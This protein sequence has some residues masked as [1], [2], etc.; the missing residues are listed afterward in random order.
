LAGGS[1]LAALML[2]G[3]IVAAFVGSMFA[4]AVHLRRRYARGTVLAVLLPIIGLA[5]L[6]VVLSLDLALSAIY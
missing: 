2:V 6:V 5:V 3:A 4:G 1:S